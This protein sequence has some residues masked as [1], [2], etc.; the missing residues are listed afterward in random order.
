[1]SRNETLGR[2]GERWVDDLENSYQ[3]IGAAAW[4][5]YKS[6]FYEGWGLHYKHL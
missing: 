2:G 4:K 6:G 5:L 1:M 3:I